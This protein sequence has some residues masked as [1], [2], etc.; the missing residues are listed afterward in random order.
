MMKYAIAIAMIRAA[1]PPMAMPAACALVKPVEPC[2]A[3][4]DVAEL[5]L[6]VLL[7]TRVEVDET[8]VAALVKPGKL[9]AAAI[10]TEGVDTLVGVAE[11]LET[12]C[13]IV[14]VVSLNTVAPIVGSVIF[15]CVGWTALGRALQML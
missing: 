1:M 5:G 6:D 14:V 4:G 11:V 12:V 2:A 3:A 7:A 10:D 9:V 8:E 13:K 15:V